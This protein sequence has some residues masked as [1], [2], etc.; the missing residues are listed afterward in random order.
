MPT[1]RF[2]TL[3]AACGTISAATVRAQATPAAAKQVLRG[4]PSSVDLMYN[5]AHVRDLQF[6]RTP[7]DIYEATKTGAL[8]DLVHTHPNE[9]VRDAI[10]ILREFGVSQ[11]PVVGAEPPVKI[12][13][14]AG[15]VSERALLDAFHHFS[16]FG[17]FAETL[18]LLE[19]HLGDLELDR[20]IAYAGRIG[21]GTVAKRVGWALERLGISLSQLESLRAH[22]TDGD[23]PL[24]PGLPPHGRHDPTWRVIENLNALPERR[25]AS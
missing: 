2:I 20:L 10:E 5:T 25:R 12:G 3:I 9:T 1:V 8:P 17:S 15:S 7:A 23:A 4:S 18:G 19:E 24:D 22:L 13:E 6:L 11:M 16:V 21:I 14:V